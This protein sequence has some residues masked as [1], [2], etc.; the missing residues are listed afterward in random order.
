MWLRVG[1]LLSLGAAV[2]IF[3][4]DPKAING[5]YL[6]VMALISVAGALG[7]R[8]GWSLLLLIAGTVVVEFV[9]SAQSGLLAALWA[10]IAIALL[11]PSSVWFVWRQPRQDLIPTLP[12]V[13]R[14]WS[15]IRTAMYSA[16]ARL[17]QWEA[18]QLEEGAFYRRSFSV[19]LWRL[20]YCCVGL[21]F[22]YVVS[23]NVQSGGN[24][25]GVG[26]VDVVVVVSRVGFV[27]CFIL[28]LG[29]VF[30]A[31][32]ARIRKAPSSSKSG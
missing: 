32:L 7:S 13:G 18:G 24:G 14:Y 25:G 23:F 27:I 5:A 31:A 1:G 9:L 11:A 2:V 29:V 19:L 10:G 3:L 12:G 30:A 17:A 26:I 15:A 16:I 28:F 22:A 21:F 4:G 8:I 6:A 20:G